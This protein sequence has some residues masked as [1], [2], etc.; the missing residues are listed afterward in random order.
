MAH[1]NQTYMQ[2]A[3][4]EIADLI[5]DGGYLPDERAAEFIRNVIK[6]SV[7]LK[8]IQVVGMRSHTKIL[9]KVGFGG[10]VLRPGVSGS[11][12]PE[13]DRVKPTTGRV[14]LTTELFKGECRL[15]DEVLEDNI[16]SGN[17]KTTVQQMLA[18]QISL[19]LDDLAANG[20]KLSADPFLAK[21]DGMR[22]LAVSHLVNAGVNPLSKSYLKSAIKKMPSQYNRNKANHVFM[23]SEMAEIDYRDYLA[24]R[25]TAVG[26]RFL[27][28]DVPV[29]YANRA[30]MP[31]PVFPDNLGGGSNCT[32]VLLMDPKTAVFGFWRRIQ[33]E[34]A[35]DA[36]SG[37]WCLIATVR[38]GFAYQEEDAVV[39]IYGVKTQ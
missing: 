2:K 33:L 8:T 14:E 22:K 29:R 32:D 21:V 3:D 34:T 11:A 39:K 16:E 23:T 30:I 19:D 17:F 27:T 9:D 1:S 10:R 36:H 6:E 26:D 38:C 24:D 37:E 28:E 35:R 7:L 5:A 12:V 4:L 25:M 13:A 18:E 31:V 20:D 15:N